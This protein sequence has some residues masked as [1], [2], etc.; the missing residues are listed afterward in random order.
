MANVTLD[1]EFDSLGSVWQTTYPWAQDGFT[2]GD[3]S[4]WFANPALLP[5]DGNP[6]S[7]GD[8]TITLSN[9]SR[10]DDVS[11]D[12]VGGMPRIGGQILT[13]HTFSQTYGYFE[14]RMQMPSGDGVGAAFWLLPE[15]GGWPPE[16]D[17]AEALGNNPTVLVNTVHD[18]GAPDPH[19]TDVA[20]MADGFHTY[21]VDWEPDTITWYFDGQQT[22]QTA[23]TPN[24]H[25]PMYMIASIT[26][27]Q[28]G[29]WS[30]S[31]DPSLM[32]QMKIDY[33]RAYDANPYSSGGAVTF[34]DSSTDTSDSS[35][36]TDTS[37]TTD[38]SNSTDTSAAPT[39]TQ[40]MATQSSGD[41]TGSTDQS[42]ADTGTTTPDT[43]NTIVI[44][45]GTD[46]QSATASSDIFVFDGSGHETTIAD[47]A[48]DSDRLDFEMTAQDFSN[49]AVS[50]ALD[51][52][53]QIDFDGNH[54]SLPG[55]SPD[56][57]SQTAFMF[58][59]GNS[60]ATATL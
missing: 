27:G 48:P 58:N 7:L 4:T 18:D 14:A 29:S 44:N 60:N 1:E 11:P 6:I 19:W 28:P 24:L 35:G 52:S 56:Q 45:G 53:A 23:T 55:V 34:S 37:E 47:F 57:L 51:G 30:G 54:V 26:S 46:W 13:E 40:A 8:G 38:S 22:F 49:V 25:Q 5:A 16:L 15:S 2:G 50:A 31:P 20:N 41:S 33:I 17:V 39:D 42:A 3:Q 9:F 43:T 36:S 10:P 32:S 59:A 12:A 21:A